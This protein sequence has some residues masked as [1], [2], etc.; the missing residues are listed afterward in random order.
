MIK[1]SIKTLL[2]L[3]SSLSLY[4]VF[5]GYAFFSDSKTLG[6]NTI[7]SGDWQTK[8]VI[9]NEIMWTGTDIS[10]DDQWIELK[11]LTNQDINI[12]K[13]KIQN[14]R[15]LNKPSLMIPANSIIPANGLF[16]ISS[17]P[18]QSK[19][20]A[21]AVE[22]D[23][24]NASIAL[25]NENNGN[26]LLKDNDGNIIDE[27]LGY[28]NWPAGSF[29]G[30]LHSMQRLNSENG[31]DS[32]NWQSCTLQDCNNKIYWKENSTNT[33]GSPKAENIF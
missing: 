31:L 14:A 30:T 24:S 21:L 2:I 20:T 17:Y 33:Y 27:I 32:S 3:I 23:W 1:I 10:E 8:F 26:L 22:T 9:I 11:N 12:G 13:W 5:G 16:L 7:S 4:C 28:P 19:N 25:L 6:E 29:G 18:M 15:D